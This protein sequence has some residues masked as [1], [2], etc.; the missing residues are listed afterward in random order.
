MTAITS[1]TNPR[2]QALRA[3]HTPKGRA[4]AGQFLVE[5]PHLLDAALEAGVLPALTLFAPEVLERTAQGRRLLGRLAE[6][7]AGGAELIEAT[8]AVIERAADTQTPQGIVASIAAAAVAPE[9]VR[10]RRRGRARPLVLILDGLSDP[11]NVGTLLRS[12]LAADVDEVWLAPGSADP[13]GPKVVRAASGAHFHLPVHANQAWDEI[14]A[15]L[16]GAPAVRQ[17]LL[18]EASAAQAYDALDLTQRSALIVGNEAHGPSREAA[19]LATVRVSIPLWNGV[20]S[21]NA[22]IAAS[23]ICFEA[24]RQRRAHQQSHPEPAPTE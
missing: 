8:A 23:V 14:A 6:A 19:A 16:R 5:G 24:G 20:E 10:A 17:V 22:A 9:A 3:L 18:A 21:L 4:E 15:W 12:A 13:L 7:R 1:T 2:V 11:G